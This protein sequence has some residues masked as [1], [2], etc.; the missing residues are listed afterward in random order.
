M[1]YSIFM[2]IERRKVAR[3]LVPVIVSITAIAGIIY[4]IAAN[5]PFVIQKLF[6][7]YFWI[8]VT[9]GIFLF[10]LV[11][12]AQRGNLKIK[13]LSIV[14]IVATLILLGLLL[15]YSSHSV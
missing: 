15:L 4:V 6:I 1:K 14:A 3:V 5:P 11:P 12:K 10:I 2:R 13:E 7:N 9:L 8:V